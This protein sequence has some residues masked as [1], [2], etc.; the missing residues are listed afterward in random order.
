M[1]AR[2]KLQ[3]VVPASLIVAAMLVPSV[4]RATGGRYAFAGGTP[5]QQAEVAR[6]LAA[7]SFDWDVVPARVTIHIRRGVLSHA[8]PGEIWLDADL[9]DAGSV[10]WGVV[11]HEYAHQVDFFLLTPPARA[12]LL[13]RLGATVWCAQTDVRRDQLGC[14][15]FASALAWAFWPSADNCMR[16]EGARPA[17]TAR[18]RKLVSGLIETNTRRAEG[19]L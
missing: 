11:Q 18:F 13:G 7:S 15:R 2:R 16:P 19:D 3:L 17:W 10:A 9:L 1:A 5:R 6:A 12:R 14:E 4:G 8:T